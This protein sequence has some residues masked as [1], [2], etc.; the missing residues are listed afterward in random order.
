MKLNSRPICFRCGRPVDSCEE[1]TDYT[2]NTVTFVV[3]CHGS[4]ESVRFTEFE[5]ALMKPGSMDF[6]VAFKPKEA[7]LAHG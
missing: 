6:A 3:R 2:M 1:L 5:L 7:L 4:R